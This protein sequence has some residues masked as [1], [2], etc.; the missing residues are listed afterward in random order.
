MLREASMKRL[1]MGLAVTVV[2]LALGGLAGAAGS[3]PSALA[4][5]DPTGDNGGAPDI[6]K[7]AVNGDATSGTLTFSITASGLALPA[8]DGTAREVDL[9]LNTDRNPSTGSPNGNEYVLFVDNDSTDAGQWTW[10]IYHFANGDWQQ[11]AETPTM[12]AFGGGNDFSIR[13]NKSDL[14]GA[15]SFDIYAT[16][17]TFDGNGNAVGGFDAAPQNAVWV[18]DIRGPSRTSTSLL[19]PTFGKPA[20]APAKVTA[21]KRLTVSFPIT[22][23]RAGKPAARLTSGTIAAAATVAGKAVAHTTSLEGGVA[24]VSLLVPRTAKGKTVRVTVAVTA[25]SSVDNDGRWLDAATG[26]QGILSTVVKGGSATKTISA[27]AH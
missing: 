12:D 9:W 5:T 15:N 6:T 19:R 1:T 27:T 23:S 14:G 24:K 21:G 2:A 13:I 18:Y 25:P 7:V 26:E 8:A 11:V 10:D 4:F 17:G 16:S 20:L 3:G 22:A